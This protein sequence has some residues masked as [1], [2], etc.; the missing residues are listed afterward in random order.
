MVTA[1]RGWTTVEG[2][3][4]QRWPSEEEAAEGEGSSDVRLLWQERRKGRLRQ[5][6]QWVEKLQEAKEIGGGGSGC[7]R[8][9]AVATGRGEE[10]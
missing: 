9:L 8:Q 3:E 2:R 5:W 7:G 6:Q 1:G 10:A 4:E